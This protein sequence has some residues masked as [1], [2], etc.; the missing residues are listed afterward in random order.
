VNKT[1][2]QLQAI[3]ARVRMGIDLPRPVRDVPHT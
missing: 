1:P 3:A 2:E